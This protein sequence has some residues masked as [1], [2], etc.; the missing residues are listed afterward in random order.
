MQSQLSIL[1]SS[2][3]FIHNWVEIYRL[4]SFRL[5]DSTAISLN[6][7]SH[8]EFSDTSSS[9]YGLSSCAHTQQ[10]SRA[11]YHQGDAQKTIQFGKRYN[12]YGSMNVAK[13]NTSEISKC[14]E[15]FSDLASKRF[16]WYTSCPNPQC[17][18]C[19]I[20]RTRWYRSL[21]EE[22]LALWWQCLDAQR[23]SGGLSNLARESGV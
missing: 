3:K 10:T 13:P 18:L 20:L 14:C 16:S 19:T 22:S 2:I 12:L 17:R 9:V 1:M 7:R 21:I 8:I 11:A 15:L 5:T 23:D 4:R 6:R